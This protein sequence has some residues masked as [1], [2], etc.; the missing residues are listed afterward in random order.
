MTT[1]MRAI[2][3]FFA[4]EFIIGLAGYM[5]VADGFSSFWRALSRLAQGDFS[6]FSDELFWATVIV[7]VAMIILQGAFL[8][9]VAFPITRNDE[10]PGWLRMSISGLA[11]AITMLVPVLY[12]A[13]MLF[14]FNR[15]WDDEGFLQFVSDHPW[16]VL[17]VGTLVLGVPMTIWMKRKWKDGIPVI[18]SI[19]IAGLVCGIL[20]AGAVLWLLTLVDLFG[21]DDVNLVENPFVWALSCAPLVGWIVATPILIRFAKRHPGDGVLDKIAKILMGG[22]IIELA[23]IIP[24]DIMVRRKNDCYC[25]SSSFF[26]LIAAGSAGFIIFGPLVLLIVGRRK[27]RWMK[28]RC[29]QCEYDMTGFPLAWR[30]PEC[31]SEDR[32]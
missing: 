10:K 24:F 9:P 3:G 11:T 28:G 15:E 1:K 25:L 6:L 32:G 26:S 12:V 22:T 4:A 17:I 29:K 23:A 21:K 8:T 27:V 2:L 19:R 30:C 20:I 18:A 31:G 7:I 14:N 13:L 5:I 16:I